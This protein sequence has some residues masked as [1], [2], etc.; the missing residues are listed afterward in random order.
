[1]PADPPTV[2]LGHNVYIAPSAYVA[3]EV[4][5]EDDCTV[6]HHVVIRGDIAAIQIGKRCNVQDG[7]IIH[8]KHSC[9]QIIGDDVSM[10]HR[11]VVHGHR[12]GSGV[13][14]GI[15]S[16]ILDD[17]QI[18]D[19]CVIAAGAL[20]PPG[21]VIPDGKVVMG[22]PGLVVRD[23]NDDDRRYARHVVASYLA[24]GRR[25]AAGHFPNIAPRA[26]QGRDLSE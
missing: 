4:T 24:L 20:L 1:M 22:I 15:G 11:A 13:L 6:M 23:V 14:V 16:I 19:G 12:I 10:G 26:R 7:A 17:C 3:G 18:G 25:H 9:P 21:T 8:T 2:T 5:L